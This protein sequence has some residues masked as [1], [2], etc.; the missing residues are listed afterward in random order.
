M[1]DDRI[2]FSAL[3][4]KRDAERFDRV[5]TGITQSAARVLAARRQPASALDLIACWKRP[6]LAAAAVVVIV[7]LAVLAGVPDYSPASPRLLALSEALGLPPTVTDWVVSDRVPGPG[8]I[9]TLFVE[10][11]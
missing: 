8:Q 5:V 4:P 3:D 6:M 10:A 1:T 7:A 9:L 11:R 2:D